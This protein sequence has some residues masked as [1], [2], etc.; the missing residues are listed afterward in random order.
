MDTKTVVIGGEKVTIKRL[1]ASEP[2]KPLSGSRPL[3]DHVTDPQNEG[4]E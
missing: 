3:H 2:A 4:S 1:P